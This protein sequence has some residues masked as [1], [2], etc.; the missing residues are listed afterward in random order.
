MILLNF[1]V[2]VH[3]WSEIFPI[4]WRYEQCCWVVFGVTG[5]SFVFVS[6]M[7]WLQ[8]LRQCV[9]DFLFILKPSSYMLILLIDD[10]A[11]LWRS[12]FHLFF[13]LLDYRCWL[14]RFVSCDSRRPGVISF[15]SDR[16]FRHLLIFEV[17]FIELVLV[18][19]V[20]FY[21]RLLFPRSTSLK[22]HFFRFTALL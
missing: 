15:E 17:T 18:V 3:A 1:P 9:I 4:L 10:R 21:C 12:W 19:A 20:L 5:L 13:L 8:E 7:F 14:P 16:T 11:F 2:L 22:I 6:D